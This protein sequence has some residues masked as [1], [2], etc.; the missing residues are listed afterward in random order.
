MFDWFSPLL[1][2]VTCNMMYKVRTCCFATSA[3][4][5]T[6]LKTNNSLI[7]NTVVFPLMLK[8]EKCSVYHHVM[9]ACSAG[10]MMLDMDKIPS[11]L[12]P[13]SKQ[14][15]TNEG[16]YKPGVMGGGGGLGGRG[17]L[18]SFFD[19]KKK[20]SL[21]KAE[22]SKSGNGGIRNADGKSREWQSIIL[23]ASSGPLM[24]D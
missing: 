13:N 20:N 11:P 19:L 2:Y 17:W 15:Q 5:G 12:R 18:L 21:W 6:I 8:R 3:I 1:L 9:L 16:S 14:G 23:K 4:S 22:L 10:S 24:K 7:L